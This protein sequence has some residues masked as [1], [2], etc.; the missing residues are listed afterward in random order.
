M[1]F[2]FKID[3]ERNPQIIKKILSGIT[4][5]KFEPKVGVKIKT[6]ETDQTV[7]GND[8]DEI[9]VENL[10]RTLPATNSIKFSF[11]V[12][13][14]EKD[15]DRNFHIDFITAASNLRAS[16][17][18]IKI[19]D[20]NQTKKIAGKIVPAIAT[21]TA[22]ITGLVCMELIKLIQKKPLE[23]F[24]NGYV[25]LA[26]PLFTFSE[27]NPPPKHKSVPGKSKAIP[28]GW[29]LWDTITINGDI[30]FQQL[31]DKIKADYK[32]NAVSIASGNSLVYNSYIPKFKDRL[33]KKVTDVWR[34][35][36]KRDFDPNQ[37][38][39]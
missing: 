33:P 18:S 8:D 12:A 22:M 23:S 30:T 34:E 16:N 3:G 13:S 31:L 28:E 32:L 39:I 5:E 6:G 20:R 14:F 9:I 21:T 26:L 15:D 10:L 24:K 29:T 17:Y 36:N 27:P 19:A 7:E 25:N 1:A 2:A 4:V 38:F 37:K 11:N 35:I